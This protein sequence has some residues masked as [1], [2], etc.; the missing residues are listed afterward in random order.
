MCV[1]ARHIIPG[2]QDGFLAKC[3]DCEITGL[4]KTGRMIHDYT[5]YIKNT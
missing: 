2:I 3:A 4:L 1:L 5:L